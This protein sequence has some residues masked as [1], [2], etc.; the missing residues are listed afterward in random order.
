MK[1]RIYGYKHSKGTFEGI[2]YDYVKI[3]SMGRLETKENQ[4]GGAGVDMRGLPE[5]AEKLGKIDLWNN[6]SGVDLEVTIEAMALGGGQMREVVVA[7]Q[8]MVQPK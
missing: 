4:R 2:A 6:G 8:P 3:F 5:L 7:V 1:M